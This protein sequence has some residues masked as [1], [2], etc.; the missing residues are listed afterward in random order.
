MSED[1]TN[2]LLHSLIKSIESLSENLSDH[3]KTDTIILREINMKLNTGRGIFI[4]AFAAFSILGTIAYNV[5]DIFIK[6]IKS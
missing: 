5:F 6:W 3:I 4:G 1:A 2:I